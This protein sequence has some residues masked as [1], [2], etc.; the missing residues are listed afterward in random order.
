[1]TLKKNFICDVCGQEIS[2]GDQQFNMGIVSINSKSWAADDRK[3]K[4]KYTYHI[5][6]SFGYHCIGKFWDWLEK[7]RKENRENK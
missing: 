3:E 5:H 7:S 2:E 6:N 4:V 1:M